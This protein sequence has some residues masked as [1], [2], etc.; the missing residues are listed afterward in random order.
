[1][2]IITRNTRNTLAA[3]LAL[4]ITLALAAGSASAAPAQH[5]VTGSLIPVPALQTVVVSTPSMAAIRRLAIQP[6]ARLTD[7]GWSCEIIGAVYSDNAQVADGPMPHVRTSLREGGKTVYTRT[8]SYGV[9]HI[10]VPSD[11]VPTVW[12]EARPEV[13]VLPFGVHPTRPR[14]T[15]P[16]A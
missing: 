9:Y 11:V 15:C 14:V 7:A 4:A 3:A 10:V 5:T 6:V 13:G 12:H 16:A 1:M 2:N 8:N